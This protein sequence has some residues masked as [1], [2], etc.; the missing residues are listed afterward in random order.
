MAK[1]KELKQESK[2]PT[3]CKKCGGRL[4]AT[5]SMCRQRYVNLDGTLGDWSDGGTEDLDYYECEKCS[6][7]VDAH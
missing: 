7:Q 3:K 2:H 1:T 5:F 4:L 6:E